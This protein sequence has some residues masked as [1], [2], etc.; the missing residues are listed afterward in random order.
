[1]S[2]NIKS[3]PRTATV[4]T[5]SA[6][7][8]QRNA[9]DVTQPADHIDLDATIRGALP[10]GKIP[11]ALLEGDLTVELERWEPADDDDEF[12]LYVTVPGSEK[13]KVDSRVGVPPGEDPVLMTIPKAFV[14][15]LK[16]GQ[17]W[18]H[19]TILQKP[20]F[21]ENDS[22][23]TTFEIDRT[24]PGGKVPPAILFSQDIVRNGLTLA[25]LRE[26][27]GERLPAIIPNYDFQE[28]GDI[29]QLKMKLRPDGPEIDAGTV[30]VTT[31][32]GQIDIVY[33]RATLELIDGAGIVEFYYYIQDQVG[34]VSE[35]APESPI[36]LLIKGAPDDIPAPLVPGFDGD[37]LVTDPDA[38]PSML[39]QIPAFTPPA[40]VGDFFRVH[41][42]AQV[43]ETDPLKADDVGKAILLDVPIPY[44]S[45]FPSLDRPIPTRFESDVWHEI[46][47]LG[48]A[49]PSRHKLVRFDLDIPGGPDPKPDPDDPSNDALARPI[50]RGATGSDD[51]VITPP[52]IVVNATAVV[53]WLNVGPTPP[54]SSF[55]A[56]DVIQ[57]YLDN[58][59]VGAP[60]RV[61]TLDEAARND[62]RL[63]VP[64]AAMR[65]HIGTPDFWYDAT[66]RVGTTPA[67]DVTVQSPA[68]SVDIRSEGELPGGGLPLPRVRFVRSAYWEQ[69]GKAYVINILHLT[70]DGGA[71][72][73]FPA[74]VN[75]QKDDVIEFTFQGFDR[76]GN[77]VAASRYVGQHVVTLL[78]TIERKDD[79]VQPPVMRGYAEALVPRGFVDA[80]VKGSANLTYTARNAFGTAPSET[81]T[82]LVDV[83]QPREG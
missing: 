71:L 43:F 42:G 79:T 47:R 29:I 69:D 58:D 1:M 60:Y 78:D 52:D 49:S 77:P 16:D 15:T 5:T 75:F 19:F 25:Q 66:R 61:S 18:L 9:A 28:P 24:A 32:A 46:V 64:S 22:N 34:H 48:M 54:E 37:G 72:V 67:Q 17:Y 2:R 41:V 6:G 56:G 82:V 33:E 11:K 12:I 76:D 59:A 80:I 21:I 31:P 55:K 4:T 51:N 53:P 8:L 74:Y 57:L 63:V 30:T 73:R 83:R 38:R 13:Q 39:V 40:Q 81:D 44:L 62:L 35:K 10:N 20:A 70:Q 45:L 3:P 7:S 14:D 50:L 26:M 23:I 27:P 36:S 65:A 68:Q